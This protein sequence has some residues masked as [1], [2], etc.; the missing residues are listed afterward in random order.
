MSELTIEHERHWESAPMF[1]EQAAGKTECYH[2][3]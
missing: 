3:S 2:A 1:A